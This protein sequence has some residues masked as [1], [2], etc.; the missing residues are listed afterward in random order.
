MNAWTPGFQM[1][2]LQSSY[3]VIILC[4]RQWVATC[5]SLFI[6]LKWSTQPSTG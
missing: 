6:V 1:E 2:D 5:V 4:D 3:R